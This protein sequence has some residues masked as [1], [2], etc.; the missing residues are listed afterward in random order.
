[1]H[2]YIGYKKIILTTDQSL[3]GVQAIDDEFLEWFVKNP[4][5][6]G[7]EVAD[8]WKDGNPSTHFSYQII[9]PQEEPKQELNLNCFDCNKSLQDC[10]CIEDTIDMKKETLEEAASRLLYSKY[11]YHPPRDS[12]YWKDMFISGANYQAERM[13]SEEEVLDVLI[14]F[15][16]TFD[17]I[18]NPPQTNTIPLWFEQ[19]KKK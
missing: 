19:F 7:V 14:E 6:E 11:P 18:K 13:Y 1:M 8:L 5:C 2:N 17:P 9:I 15:Y 10:T 16:K 3:D 12:G 4:S